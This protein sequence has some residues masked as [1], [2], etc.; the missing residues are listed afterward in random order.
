MTRIRVRGGLIAYISIGVHNELHPEHIVAS[1]CSGRLKP[2]DS[3]LEDGGGAEATPESP[4]ALSLTSPQPR[5][6]ALGQEP[7]P[8]SMKGR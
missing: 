1:A 4:S 3:Y 5:G 6:P 8:H 7:R 2:L